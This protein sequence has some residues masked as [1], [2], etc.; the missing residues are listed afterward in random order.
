MIKI[1]YFLI[2]ILVLLVGG[3]LF[4]SGVISENNR[5]IE[6]I[7]QEHQI[8]QDKIGVLF[9]DNMQL[10]DKNEV[11]EGRYEKL[12]KEKR[13]IKTIIKI[14][15]I[16]VDNKLYV[17]KKRYDD[18]ESSYN[19]VCEKFDSYKENTKKIKVNVIE[20]NKEIEEVKA[21]RKKMKDQYEKTIKKLNKG[22]I[23]TFGGTMTLCIDGKVRCGI[24]VTFGKRIIRR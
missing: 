2:A 8:S 19:K 20:I 9:K 16:K 22:W 17:P 18:M 5:K 11:I 14:K 21:N 4:R 15:T 13:K 10:F 3:Y 12:K 1:K 6:Q 23:L 24:G 7:E